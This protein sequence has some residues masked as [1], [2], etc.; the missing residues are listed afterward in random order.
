MGADQLTICVA[1]LASEVGWAVEIG[2]VVEVVVQATVK[3]ERRIS[4]IITFIDIS[5]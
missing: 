1:L 2:G 4:E 5:S 3:V